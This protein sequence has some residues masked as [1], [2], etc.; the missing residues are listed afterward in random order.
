MSERVSISYHLKVPLATIGTKSIYRVPG[1]RRLKVLC[2]NVSY[3]LNTNFELLVA[4]YRGIK[5]LL[6]TEGEYVGE[7]CTIQDNTEVWW[8]SD[9]EIILWY[10]NKSPSESKN[11]NIVLECE[12]LN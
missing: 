8:G 12:L 4:F 6:P 10:R 9:E 1:G 3:P 7:L 2:C 5:K 11:C